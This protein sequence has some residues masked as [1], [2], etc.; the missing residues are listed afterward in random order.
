MRKYPKASRAIV[1]Q[2]FAA[3]NEEKTKFY[4]ILSID[5]KAKKTL[6]KLAG[7]ATLD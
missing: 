6:P 1:V 5:N 3:L 4:S 7:M 2:A